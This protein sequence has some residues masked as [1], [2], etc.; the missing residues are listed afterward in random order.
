MLSSRRT[1]SACID[2]QPLLGPGFTDDDDRFGAPPRVVHR[3]RRCGRRATAATRD[4]IGRSIKVDDLL[5]TVAGVM[6][7][8][9]RFPPNTDVWLPMGQSTLV[10]GQGRQLRNYNVIGRLAD[11]VTPAQAQAELSA[12]VTRLANDYPT[13][14]KDIV[15]DGW[16]L[17]TSGRTDAQIRTRLPGADGRRRVRAAHRVLERGQPAA[18]ARGAPLA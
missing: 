16:S 3:L 5:A 10:H 17:T 14:N 12:I 7:K 2:E 13:T 4:I 11:G 6:P 8:G 15:A 1:S 18:R 9:M